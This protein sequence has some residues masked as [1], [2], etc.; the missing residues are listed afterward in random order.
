MDQTIKTL[1]LLKQLRSRAVSELTG[2]L[3]Q[4]KQLCQRYQNNIDALTS[5]NDDTQVKPGDSPILMNNQ[6][7]YK[8]H[9]RYLINWQQQEFAMADNQAKVLQE[10]LVKE[11]CREKT[12]ELVLDEQKSDI[13]LEEDRKQQKVTDALSAQCWLRGR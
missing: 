11:A 7:H 5:L 8:N 4:Q 12:V 10:N 2:Q 3:S 6:S 1:Q 13:A 9:L